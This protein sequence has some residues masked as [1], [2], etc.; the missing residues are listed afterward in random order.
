MFWLLAS[1][2]GAGVLFAIFFGNWRKTWWPRHLPA[3]GLAVRC[4]G[5][6]GVALRLCLLW[7][8]HWL[9]WNAARHGRYYRR[10][11]D[12]QDRP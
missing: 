4:I 12:R 9:M 2:L 1:Y 11:S 7:P 6:A 3:G 10:K 8:L 5:T